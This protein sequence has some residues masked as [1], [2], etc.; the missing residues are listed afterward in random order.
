MTAL[1]K[2]AYI[3]KL[4]KFVKQYYSYTIHRTTIIKPVDGKPKT[5]R[6]FSIDFNIK[7]LVIMQ[8]SQSMKIYFQ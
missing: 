2:N 1:S 7:T 3:D 8:E 5:Y 6:D 4:P